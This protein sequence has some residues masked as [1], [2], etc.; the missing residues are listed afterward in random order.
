MTKAIRSIIA[1]VIITTMS[2]MYIGS[3]SVKKKEQKQLLS[4]LIWIVN[5]K[6]IKCNALYIYI[7]IWALG[8]MVFNATFNNISVIS[9]ESVLLVEETGRKPPTCRKSLTNLSHNVVPWSG[10]EPKASVV[11]GTNCIGG[12]KS[13]YHMIT[14]TTTSSLQQRQLPTYLTTL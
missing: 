12:W 4:N 13:N 10:F 8:L 5:K 1:T 11:I 14:A 6:N 2:P 9:W 3:F 7:H